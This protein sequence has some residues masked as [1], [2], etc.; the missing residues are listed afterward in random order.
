[1]LRY[2]TVEKCKRRK[3]NETGGPDV[4]NNINDKVCQPKYKTSSCSGPERAS[5]EFPDGRRGKSESKPNPTGG[6]TSGPVDRRQVSF[7]PC[8]HHRS[9]FFNSF[10]TI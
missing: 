1:M 2:V 6:A 3:V 7:L 8:H 4:M 10:F 9:W 5:G